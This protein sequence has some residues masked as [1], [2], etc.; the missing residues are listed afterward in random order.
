M[1]RIGP[2]ERSPSFLRRKRK[3]AATS[4]RNEGITFVDTL[5]IAE[6]TQS[7]S[8]SSTPDPL[9]EVEERTIEELL[10]EI[11][12]IGE[13]LKKHPGR[14]PVLKYKRAVKRLVQIAVDRGL[15]LEEQ[16]SS[17]NVLR[18]KRFTL[19]RVIDE[20]LDRLV[21]EVLMSQRETLNILGKID[22]INGLLV[23]LTS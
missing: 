14:E 16:M 4:E 23:D 6:S 12:S 3:K 18:Q 9:S 22:E 19:V 17:P 21:S 13:G 7:A 11:F 20:K 15:R 8:V 2:S 5:S 1:E 10:D